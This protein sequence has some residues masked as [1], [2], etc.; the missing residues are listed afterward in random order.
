MASAVWA[1]EFWAFPAW[2]AGVDL[3]FADAAGWGRAIRFTHG[4]GGHM[5][6]LQ[7][8]GQAVPALRVTVRGA[9]GRPAYPANAARLGAKVMGA[10]GGFGGGPLARLAGREVLEPPYVVG[11]SDGRESVFFPSADTEVEHLPAR[12]GHPR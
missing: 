4:A 6:A 5:P 10:P 7:V 1:P 12:P 2:A 3:M 11:W 9:Q 8:A